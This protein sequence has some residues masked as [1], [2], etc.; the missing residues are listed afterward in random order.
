MT[1]EKEVSWN[2]KK[3]RTIFEK[4]SINIIPYEYNHC[5][6]YIDYII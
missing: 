3:V 5:Y 4:Q 1:L 2:E 6:C